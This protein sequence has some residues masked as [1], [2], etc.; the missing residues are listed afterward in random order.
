MKYNLNINQIQALN[1]GIKNIN[2]AHIFDLLT[3][4]ST[5][6]TTEIVN[7]NV[8]YFVA[9]QMIVEE[10]KLLNLK[11]DTVYRHLKSLNKI[12]LIDYIKVGKK[13]CIRITEKGKKYLSKSKKNNSTMS[14]INSNRY[15][16]NKS[17]LEQ[18]SEINL[19]KS[20]NN[21]ENNSEI[22]PTYHYTKRDHYT[23][24]TLSNSKE[25]KREISFK[26]FKEILERTDFEFKTQGLGYL[27]EHKGFQI[28]N[29]FIFNLHSQKYLDAE[30]AYK[31]WEFLYKHKEEVL[32]HAS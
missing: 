12:N 31:I 22:N 18:N 8:Y 17:E 26:N 5:W 21:S 4:A 13:D 32:K 7:N 23:N 24:N 2:Q 1:L 28:K 30:E 20:E 6:A 15:V 9:R 16:G 27:K 14:E 11:P 25:Q 29:G 10:L 3:S 19:R